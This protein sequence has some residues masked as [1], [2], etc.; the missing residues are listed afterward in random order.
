MDEGGKEYK[1]RKERLKVKILVFDKL[2][3]SI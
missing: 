3:I 2:I 1:E